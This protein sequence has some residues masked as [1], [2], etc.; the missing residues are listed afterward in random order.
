[1]IKNVT[2]I[3]CIINDEEGLTSLCLWWGEVGSYM[4][5]DKD[6]HDPRLYC[7][8]EDQINGFYTMTLKY[9][10]INNIVE[11]TLDNGEFFDKKLQLQKV[12]VQILDLSSF[13]KVRNILSLLF[14]N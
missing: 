7:E 9:N 13:E 3:E 6:I 12:S 14:N 2:K 5:I 4:S 8:F 1:M 10:I 11:F